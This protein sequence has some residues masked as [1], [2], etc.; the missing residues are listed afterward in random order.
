MA[1]KL[2][3]EFGADVNAADSEGNTALVDCLIHTNPTNID[4]VNLLV[5]KYH[6]TL[7]I[8][9]PEHEDVSLDTSYSK[10]PLCLAIK[11][12]WGDLVDLF[13]TYNALVTRKALLLGCSQV[14]SIYLF[15]N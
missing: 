8:D 6:S 13:L 10:T 14:L 7:E 9:E 15:S 4:L 3:E 5:R 11:N 1:C 12:N 2:L